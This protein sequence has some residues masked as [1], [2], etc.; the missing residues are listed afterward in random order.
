[1]T[2]ACTLSIQANGRLLVSSTS[3]GAVLW[4]NEVLAP[5]SGPFTI[6]LTGG[7]LVETDNSGVI[8]W[9]AAG[10][11]AECI[12]AVQMPVGQV[13]AAATQRITTL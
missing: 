12:S 9:V 3:S 7:R 10:G 1:M 8:K 5:G 13:Q 2:Q 6:T 4:S 11:P